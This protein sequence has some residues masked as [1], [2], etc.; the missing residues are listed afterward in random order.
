MKKN[1]IWVLVV[2]ISFGAIIVTMAANDNGNQ[3]ESQ[4]S[5]DKNV[6]CGNLCEAGVCTCTDP[7]A[8]VIRCDSNGDG[9][10]DCWCE[11][12]ST[13]CLLPLDGNKVD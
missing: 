12:G 3:G 9:K 2:A 8:D 6:N 10:N 13:T 4:N 11:V 5:D 7:N 1:L